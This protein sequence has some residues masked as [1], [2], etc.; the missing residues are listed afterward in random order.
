MRA[1]LTA[2]TLQAAWLA[3]TAGTGRVTDFGEP[4]K[5]CLRPDLIRVSVPVVCE[6]GQFT[7]VMSVDSAGLLNGLRLAP[8]VGEPWTAPSYA[9]PGAFEEHDVMVG[10][11]ALAVGGTLLVANAPLSPLRERLIPVTDTVFS[12]W[13]SQDWGLFAPHVPG[14]DRHLML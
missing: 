10:A 6:R 14:Q 4:S 9:D 8:P 5:E 11:G 12:P 13:F 1:A 7:A 2:E 3:H